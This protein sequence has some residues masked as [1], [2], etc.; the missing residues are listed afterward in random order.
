[1]SAPKRVLVVLADGFEEIEAVTPIDV[2]RRAGLTV[3]VAGIGR[4]TVTGAHGLALQADIE[5]SDY[6]GIPDAI[7]LPGGMPGAA[8]LAASKPL[9]G[10]IQ[11]TYE[12]GKWVAAIC[13]SP[14]VVLAPLG[15][16]DG[17]KAT[18]YPGFESR[19]GARVELSPDR[20]I[21][22]G[23]VLTSKGPGTALEFSLK[24]AAELAG[25]SAAE[26]LTDGM[27]VRGIRV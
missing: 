17:K 11:K 26:Q 19:L 24:L 25:A 12:A 14:A 15:V 8:N 21:M 20:V 13:A 18:C 2:L 5:L 23:N 3:T 27:I 9:A 7:V 1:M 10:L 22:A 16:L 4:T 6:S